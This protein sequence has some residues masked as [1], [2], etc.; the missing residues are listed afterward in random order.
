MKIISWNCQG[1]FR[2]K[3]EYLLQQLP[4]L[5]IVQECEHPDKLNF[6][7]TTPQPNNLLWYGD[8]LNKGLGI[9]SYGTLKLKLHPTYNPEFK[10]IVPLEVR[11]LGINITLIAI[12]ANNPDDKEGRYIEQIWKAVHYYEKLLKKKHILLAGDFNSN[13]IW[14][15]PRRVGNH[16]ALVEKLLNKKIHSVY[17]KHFAQVQG[18][19]Y[20]PTFY[21]H[22]NKEKPY[23][24]DYCF[25]SENLLNKIQSFDIGSY[26]D[27]ISHS[28]HTPVI[29]NIDL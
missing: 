18:T 14:D 21:L 28:D 1:A 7:T 17:H 13:T 8:N 11:G 24:L 16:S 10:I 22:R 5:L 15:R 27:W 26:E 25:V 12:W 6:S 2:K 3:S 9:F 23:H 29:I 20:H 4:D 19:E